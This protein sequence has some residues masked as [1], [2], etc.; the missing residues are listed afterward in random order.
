MAKLEMFIQEECPYC[1]KARK[2]ISELV[3]E[4][5]EYKNVDIEMI[6]EIADPQKADQYDYWYVPTFYMGKEKLH[7]GAASK[8]DIENVLKAA[9]A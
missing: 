9:L 2:Y 3:E 8:V 4:H 6:D 7:E 1:K 5:P